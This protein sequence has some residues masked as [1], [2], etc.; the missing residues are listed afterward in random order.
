M[1][2]KYMTEKL[3][4]AYETTLIK[5]FLGSTLESSDEIN[6]ILSLDPDY[7]MKYIEVLRLVAEKVQEWTIKWKS[8]I[9]CGDA[10]FSWLSA[11]MNC[12]I[13]SIPPIQPRDEAIKFLESLEKTDQ[14]LVTYPSSLTLNVDTKDNIL[15]TSFPVSVI[16]MPARY[17]WDVL[18][19]I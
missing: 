8:T 19:N 16:Y 13:K 1:Q 6:T 17:E 15:S 18:K 12:T 11:S 7:R 14:L 5:K 9:S 10:K 2:E 4:E 3:R